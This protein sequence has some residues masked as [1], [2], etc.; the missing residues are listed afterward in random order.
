MLRIEIENDGTANVPENIAHPPSGGEFCII[1]NYDY[2]IFIN[3][4]LVAQGR[5]EN[6][7][8]LSMWPGL[9]SCLN[10][11]VNGTKFEG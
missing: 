2:R 8:R 1:G 9:I 11:E 10:R 4:E 3:S 5:I 7:N 6:H